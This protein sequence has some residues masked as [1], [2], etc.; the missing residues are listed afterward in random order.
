MAFRQ[1]LRDIV[2]IGASAGGVRALRQLMVDLPT[3]FPGTIA[4]VQHRSPFHPDT[5]AH[6]IAD[7]SKHVVRE[8]EDGE[9]VATGRV[10]LAP[11][12]RHLVITNDVFRLARGP[13]EHFTRP[14]IDMLFRSAAEAYG[15]RV[16]G[17][18]MTG[19]GRDGASGLNAIKEAGGLVLIQDPADAESPA[20]PR[21]ALMH[22]EPDA[23]LSLADLAPAVAAL[24]NGEPLPSAGR[25]ATQH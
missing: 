25:A 14:A 21:Y 5:L 1:H 4:I 12:D 22:C 20:M 2:V 7:H 13:K 18:V 11:R 17:V 15:P 6:V 10:Y 23:V 9:P 16:V 3:S 8:P 19:G 24:M